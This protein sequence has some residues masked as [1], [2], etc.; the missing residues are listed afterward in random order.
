MSEEVMD[1][2]VVESHADWSAR[3]SRERMVVGPY[4]AR[5]ALHGAGLLALVEQYMASEDADPLA[6][7]AWQNATEF[8]RLSNVVQAVSQALGLTDE[9]LD[10]LFKVAATL[11]A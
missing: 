7:L 1:Q 3:V 5:A 11:E 9:Q 2:S 8:R 6:V 10:E 4:Q